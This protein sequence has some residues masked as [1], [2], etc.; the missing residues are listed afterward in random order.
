M[1]PISRLL[2]FIPPP[3]SE[4]P[5][6]VSG[7]G[8]RLAEHVLD[9]IT[10]LLN[11]SFDSDVMVPFFLG[12]SLPNLVLAR[13]EDLVFELDDLRSTFCAHMTAL[14]NLSPAK[15]FLLFVIPGLKAASGE[16]GTF[17]WMSYGHVQPIKPCEPLR[18][19]RT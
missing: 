3:L 16:V 13:L 7:L 11:I 1:M 19:I 6:W 9:Q 15:L 12:K 14:R 17:D 4:I 2:I 5:W 8:C 18:A 10:H